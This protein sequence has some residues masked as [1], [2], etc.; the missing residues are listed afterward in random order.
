MYLLIVL[1][2]RHRTSRFDFNGLEECLSVRKKSFQLPSGPTKKKYEYYFTGEFGFE[3]P[4]IIPHAYYRA[5]H[6]KPYRTIGCGKM[7][8]FY[9]F[10][11]NHVDDL[12]C[13]RGTKGNQLAMMSMT[14]C[15]NRLIQ[16]CMLKE[17][18]ESPPFS[19]YY[20]GC[21][22]SF[23]RNM[24][25]YVVVNNKYSREKLVNKTTQ[26]AK[27][28]AFNHF[29]VHT[30]GEIFDLFVKNGYAVVY[31]QPDWNYIE[32]DGQNIENELKIK[33]EEDVREMIRTYSR[34]YTVADLARNSGIEYNLLQLHILSLAQVQVSVQGG[35]GV[36]SSLWG[37]ANFI[38]HRRGR[39]VLAGLNNMN[40]YENV[41][42][43]ISGSSPIVSSESEDLL[44]NLVRYLENDKLRK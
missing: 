12:E 35:I 20:K 6:G 26:E 32:H 42:T 36:L 31:N 2:R 8:P 24:Q 43:R 40:Y 37:Q 15:R 18:W 16:T 33:Q 4:L 21:S 13:K 5:K 17:E 10:S 34:V 41:Y 30:L 14:N 29:N 27:F 7:A 28:G 38:L 23:T 1:S 25:P 22:S 19:E 44:M 3:L 39:E 9:F 11:P